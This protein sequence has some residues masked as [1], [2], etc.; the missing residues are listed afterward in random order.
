MGRTAV[1]SPEAIEVIAQE[2]EKGKGKGKESRSLLERDEGKN[3]PSETPEVRGSKRELKIPAEQIKPAEPINPRV[4]RRHY[5]IVGR[6]EVK[7]YHVR[8]NNIEALRE[9]IEEQ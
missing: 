5:F 6:E 9:E 4:K 8:L 2:V 3:I 1:L 7:R